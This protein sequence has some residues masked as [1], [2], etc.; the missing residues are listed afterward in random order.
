M[1]SGIYK[2]E[3]QFATYFLTLGVVGWVDIFTRKEC[4][5]I[6][7]DGLKFCQSNKGLIIY[8]YVI[9]SN[10]LHLIASAEVSKSSGLSS[11]IRDFKR[12]TSRKILDWTIDNRKESRRHWMEIVFKYYAKYNSNNNKFQVWQQYNK[13]KICYLP[14]FTMQ[15]INYIHRNPVE[16]EMVDH[17]CD[18]PYSSARNYAGMDNC[19]LDVQVLEFGPMVGYLPAIGWVS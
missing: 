16:A 13:P 10:H 19:V 6:I 12:H 2:I 14:Y 9:M 7:I 8:A 5:Q 4:R 15:K 18:Y 17:P 3:D 11:I 1:R